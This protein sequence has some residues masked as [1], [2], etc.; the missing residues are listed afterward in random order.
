[1]TKVLGAQLPQGL[2][3]SPQLFTTGGQNSFL[4]RGTHPEQ[5]YIQPQMTSNATSQQFSV[6]CK[7]F[8]CRM[9]DFL[10]EM[11]GS[12]ELLNL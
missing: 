3:A 1:M 8:F 2:W 11:L 10:L 4:I 9:R 6:Q 12:Y 5:M 7:A